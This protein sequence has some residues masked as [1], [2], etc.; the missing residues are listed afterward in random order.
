MERMAKTDFSGERD[1]FEISP[2]QADRRLDRVLRARYSSVPLGAIMKG[3]RK[4]QVRVNGAR[5]SGETRLEHGDRVTTPW[6]K[7]EPKTKAV[8]SRTQLETIYKDENIWCV[9]K[10]PGLLSQPDRSTDESV[11]TAAWAELAWDRDDFRPAVVHR[12]DR[13][14]SGAMIIAL[15]APILRTL[16]ELI[17][18]NEI[19]KTYRAIVVGRIDEPGEINVPL[20]KN[21]SDNTVSV[22]DDGRES[23]TR[24][25]PIAFGSGL[26][27]VELDLVTGRPHQARVHMAHIGHPI[28]GDSKYGKKSASENSKRLF[29]HSYSLELPKLTDL[30]TELRGKK[31]IAPMPKDFDKTL[32]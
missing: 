26:T 22:S 12:L 2:D 25:R 14:V 32:T 27:L 3:I 23:L 9:N 21:E 18:L 30:P 20:L 15:R 5:A 1:E 10:P 4:G 13:N 16:S 6:V 28:V 24:Y 8:V 29:L 19:K 7:D 31:F 11:V 17:R